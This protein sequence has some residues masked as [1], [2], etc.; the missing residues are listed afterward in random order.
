MNPVES[1]VKFW[2]PFPDRLKVSLAFAPSSR[3]TA[4]TCG[5]KGKKYPDLKA[6][7][8]EDEIKL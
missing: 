4:L 6:L 3:S 1:M 5:E 8:E 2:L 7:C